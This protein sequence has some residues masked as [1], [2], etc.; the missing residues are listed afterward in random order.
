METPDVRKLLVGI[1]CILDKLGVPYLITG[2]MA[3]VM[4]GR[5]RFTADID[6]VVELPTEKSHLLER[7]L[8]ELSKNGYVDRAAIEEA[9]GR[10]GEFNFIDGAT[11][12]KVDFWIST[13]DA[14]DISRLARRV[15]KNILEQ[16]ICFSSPEDLILVKLRWF[17]ESRSTRHIEDIRSI[18]AVSGHELDRGYLQGWVEKL[19]L[20][21]ILQESGLGDF[22]S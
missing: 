17:A 6:I 7:A 20:K 11:G 10:K 1:A 13:G 16:K 21:N 19:G 5:P 2:G 14:F 8:R 3:V 22:F 18:L 4:W 12:V 9:I 15:A